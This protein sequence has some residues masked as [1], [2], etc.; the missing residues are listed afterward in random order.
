MVPVSDAQVR[1]C[2][3]V[4]RVWTVCYIAQ[5]TAAV[6]HVL[7]DYYREPT[8][9]TNGTPSH[10]FS[11]LFRSFSNDHYV[12]NEGDMVFYQKGHTAH[13]VLNVVGLSK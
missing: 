5:A 7:G 13:P 4:C 6:K 2:V 9:S 3:C 1:V 12:S 11:N 8:K 10:L